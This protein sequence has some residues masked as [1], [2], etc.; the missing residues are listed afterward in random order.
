MKRILLF[1][2]VVVGFLLAGCT[3]NSSVLQP[4]NSDLNKKAV[5]SDPATLIKL[6]F[7]FLNKHKTVNSIIY[8]YIGGT[9]EI[10]GKIK[11]GVEYHGK[12][13][14]PAGAFSGKIKFTMKLDNKYAGFDFGPD[15]ATF[16]LPLLFTGDI[17]GLDLNGV[18]PNNLNFGFVDDNG[19]FEPV[20]YDKLEINIKE[21]K[22]KVKNAQ[23]KHFSRYNWAK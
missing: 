21:G 13:K 1:S 19:N 10:E 15:G 20:V 7:S 23:L 12:L 2:F 9:V 17:E 18:D 14:V 5:Q 22:V 4:T 16:V 11:K 6:P 3:D 8:G